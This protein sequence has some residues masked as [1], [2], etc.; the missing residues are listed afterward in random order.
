M[1]GMK[2]ISGMKIFALSY[3]PHFPHLTNHIFD[4][5]V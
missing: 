3:F 5:P 4:H 2:V 1:S